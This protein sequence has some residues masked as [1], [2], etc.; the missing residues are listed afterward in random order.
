MRIQFAKT[1]GMC[2]IR[3]SHHL[4]KLIRLKEKILSIFSFA[5]AEHSIPVMWVT[6]WFM[7]YYIPQRSSLMYCLEMQDGNSR[8]P[9]NQR[10]GFVWC[11]LLASR[12]E[13]EVESFLFKVG[14]TAV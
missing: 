3:E 14:F 7:H 13:H 11:R 2:L 8:N 12:A 10:R 6:S 9:G 4:L 5:Q 1:S